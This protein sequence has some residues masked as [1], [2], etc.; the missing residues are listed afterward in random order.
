MAFSDDQMTAQSPLFPDI[1]PEPDETEW[2]IL[3]EAGLFIEQITGKRAAM[4]RAQILSDEA[5]RVYW[6]VFEQESEC[7]RPFGLPW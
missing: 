7:V 3:D 2:F 6:V 5:E 1:V 4:S